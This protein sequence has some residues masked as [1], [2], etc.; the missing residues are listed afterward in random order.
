MEIAGA[1]QAAAA[2]ALE[3]TKVRREMVFMACVNV[4]SG[5]SKLRRRLVVSHPSR[6]DKD[7]ARMGHPRLMVTLASQLQVLRLRARY[8][9]P[10]LRMTVQRS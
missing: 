8:A 1:A 3:R 9:R 10:S 6:K 7:A 2:R 4:L 5:T